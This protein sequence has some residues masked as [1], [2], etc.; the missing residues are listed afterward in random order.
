MT[1]NHAGPVSN[2]VKDALSS[3]DTNESFVY[4]MPRN[5]DGLNSMR[6]D[7]N[8]TAQEVL[9]EN[10]ISDLL[11]AEELLLDA[12]IRLQSRR[13]DI[14][15]ALTPINI[16]PPEIM[17]LIF[18]F[19]VK[20][21]P[22]QS[23]YITHPPV[24][25]S[26]SYVSRRWRDI[27]L[28]QRE[29][30]NTVDMSWRQ[31]MID[32]WRSRLGTEGFD[33]V[34]CNARSGYDCWA[35][36]G[37]TS[38][39]QHWRKFILSF[40]DDEDEENEEP[41]SEGMEIL[42]SLM[43]HG[44]DFKSLEELVIFS[45]SGGEIALLSNYLPVLRILTFNGPSNSFSPNIFSPENTFHDTLVDLSISCFPGFDIEDIAVIQARF[46]ALQKLKIRINNQDS[47]ILPVQSRVTIRLRCLQVDFGSRNHLSYFVGRYSPGNLEGLCFD[48]NTYVDDKFMH[49]AE[50][51][52]CF[53]S[54]L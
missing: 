3:Q 40:S 15:A 22:Q 5:I 51:T 31:N 4:P 32:L 19:Y 54:Q 23:P 13:H 9:L 10:A 47:K 18:H 41:D 26:L 33:T 24:S 16:L 12:R 25:P 28:G 36:Q 49:T 20:N 8:M 29:L 6:A 37:L 45:D 1:S 17:R 44:L 21:S 14:A 53:V 39:I 38:D 11:H 35:L 52:Q 48:N 50:N 34:K 42:Q 30:W 7:P 43:N 46:P 27:A 2:A